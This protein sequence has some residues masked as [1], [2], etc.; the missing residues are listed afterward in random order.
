MVRDR[1]TAAAPPQGPTARALVIDPRV[2]A[3]TSG[4]DVV[5][6]RV[7]KHPRNPLF[8]EDY[9]SVPSR[10]WETRFD[11]VY[12]SVVRDPDSGLFRVW[13]FSF[14]TDSDMAEVPLTER[15]SR[16][17]GS[18]D[19]EDGLL[20]AESL[21]GIT[22]S[23]PELGLIEFQG[24]TANNIVMST[25]SHGI[26]AGGVLL[27]EHETDPAR[28]YKAV[29]RN[30]RDRTM[31]V[32]FSAD[33]LDWSEPVPWTEH[34]AVGDTHTNGFW[35]PVRQ[36][37]VVVTRGW[38]GST[39]DDP[40]L[41]E[42]IVL[43]TESEDFLTWTEP[44]E[45][46][47]GTGEHDQIYS[48]PIA[49]YDDLYIGLP[50]VFHKGEPDASDWDLVDTELAISLDTEKWSRVAP[51]TPVIPRGQGT[52]PT[53]AYDCG[54]IYA[55]PPIVVDDQIWLY[56][57]GSNGPHNGFRES[58]LNLASLP[59][60]RWAG[61]SAGPSGGCVT[62]TALVL[63]HHTFSLN[64]ATS[65]AGSVRAAILTD[66]GSALNGFE[67]DDCAPITGDGLRLSIR[68]SRELAELR[69]TPVR[70][71]FEFR[72]AVVYAINGAT[73]ATR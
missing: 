24:S 55:S 52:Y 37:Y 54:C 26:H 45:V 58:S 31:A 39:P 46:L 12:P 53:G 62:T 60:D 7:Q 6:G 38:T 63:D 59:I 57:G 25:E 15:P 23:K 42:R 41:G 2:I 21:D 56:Y 4:V 49:R 69:D 1:V 71:R 8:G 44:R 16:T 35:D 29:F 66:D 10:R 20:Y 47:R 51:G 64:V 61:Y 40:Y 33:G 17:Y 19:R 22:W 28:R 14:L 50:A 18:P 9:F 5:L 11:N 34:S 36:R 13:Y 72:D 73:K 3:S 48:M 68:W 70:L 32:S 67:I 43:R 30:R 65:Q 27:D